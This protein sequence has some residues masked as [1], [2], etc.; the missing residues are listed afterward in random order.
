MANT[1]WTCKRVRSSPG[2]ESST[3]WHG[4]DLNP[5]KNWDRCGN[6][7]DKGCGDARQTPVWYMI[8]RIPKVDDAFFSQKSRATLI[9]T[10]D[11]GYTPSKKDPASSQLILAQESRGLF[12]MEKAKGCR[13]GDSALTNDLLKVA[14]T[15]RICLRISCIHSAF[16]K[17]L[18]AYPCVSS[19]ELWDFAGFLGCRLWLQIL[20][21]R[22]R[23]QFLKKAGQLNRQARSKPEDDKARSFC[24]VFFFFFLPPIYFGDSVT[25]DLDLF[26]AFRPRQR[27]DT[28]VEWFCSE[29]DIQIWDD[30]R[31]SHVTFSVKELFDVIV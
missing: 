22:N 23:D 10:P 13:G 12:G 14:A 8:C 9:I 4:P 17:I 26:E 30:K 24:L 31:T 25:S 2:N 19:F 11:L 3:I 28:A 5:G 18:S 16:C 21:N 6:S 7:S 27:T 29:F 1:F 20:R 15:G